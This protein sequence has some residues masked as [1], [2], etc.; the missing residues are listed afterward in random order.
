MIDQYERRAAMYAAL[1]AYA[2]DADRRRKYKDEKSA[3]ERMIKV[4]KTIKEKKP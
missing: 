2:E 4:L 3:C 1:A